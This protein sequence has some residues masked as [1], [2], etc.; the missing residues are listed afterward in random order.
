MKQTRCIQLAPGLSPPPP[1]VFSVQ[2]VQT[3]S[4]RRFLG[5]PNMA[6]TKIGFLPQLP[7]LYHAPATMAL[8]LEDSVS[9]FNWLCFYIENC[10]ESVLELIAID[11]IQRISLL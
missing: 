1:G 9:S 11:F 5:S 7:V 3:W 6:P 2:I 4:V 10:L 8:L